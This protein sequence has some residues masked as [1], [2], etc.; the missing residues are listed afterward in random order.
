MIGEVEF[1]G[2][3]SGWNIYSCQDILLPLQLLPF[4]DI[5]RI[6]Q[7]DD[8]RFCDALRIIAGKIG[9]AA[10]SFLA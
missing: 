7:D 6:F 1:D 3:Q 4:R 8:F 10:D 5:L 2:R 9:G